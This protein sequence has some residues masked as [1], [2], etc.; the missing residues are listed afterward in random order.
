MDS[1]IANTIRIFLL[2]GWGMICFATFVLSKMIFLMSQTL[3]SP[4]LS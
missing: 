4:G 1:K 2:V 3:Y